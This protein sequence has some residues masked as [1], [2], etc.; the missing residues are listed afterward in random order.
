MTK[1]TLEEIA[2][3]A[4]VSPATVSRVINN[5]PHVRKELRVRVLQVIEETGYQPHSTARSLAARQ[6]YALGLVIP[7]STESFFSDPY[8]PRLTQALAHACNERDYVL[9]LFLLHTREDERK[10][11]PRLSQPGLLDGLVVQVGGAKDCLVPKLLAEGKIPFVVAGRPTE[12]SEHVSYVDVDNVG[13]AYE[14]VNHLLRLGRRR[15]ATITGALD[16]TAGLDRKLGYER[17]LE[18][19]GLPVTEALIA[20][21]DFTV[22]SGY[23]AMQRLVGQRPDAVFVA[24]DTMALGVLRALRQAGLDVPEDVAV[25]GYDDLPPATQVSPP[26]TTVHQPIRRFGV[27]LVTL[28]LELIAAEQPAPRH[29]IFDTELVIRQSC[30]AVVPGST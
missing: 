29:V 11:Y 3:R 24:S 2:R 17:A 23:A 19:A 18:E 22:A 1:L 27:R 6:T 4:G 16:S 14:A 9:S 13:G 21:G 28:L 5:R 8:F 25:V 26:L 10:L 12:G 7:R 15:V 20:E 30:G